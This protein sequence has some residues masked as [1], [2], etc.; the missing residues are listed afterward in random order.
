ME[1]VSASRIVA[2]AQLRCGVGR[3]PCALTETRCLLVGI[4]KP[5]DFCTKRSNL[6]FER[7]YYERLHRRG[8]SRKGSGSAQLDLAAICIWL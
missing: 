6:F 4:F 5:P 7:E 3:Q 1:I 2:A 8:R